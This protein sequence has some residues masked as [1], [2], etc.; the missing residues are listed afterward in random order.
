[1]EYVV[2]GMACIFGVASLY[3]IVSWSYMKAHTPWLLWTIVPHII[4]TVGL[5]YA[6]QMGWIGNIY[7][8]GLLHM[9]EITLFW[10]S[11][12]D[13][14]Y[15][16]LPDEGAVIICI[17]GCL[18]QWIGHSLDLYVLRNTLC[19]GGLWWSLRY[20][21]RGGVGLGDIKWLMAI[22]IWLSPLECLL[23]CGLSSVVGIVYS[24]IHRYTDPA[25]SYIPFGPSLSVAT[26]VLLIY[27]VARY[28]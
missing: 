11:T 5:Q 8:L 14:L 4:G 21:S 24:C 10:G 3:L 20:M 22:S 25:H 2:G 23:L 18:Y 13:K 16:I 17:C 12:I 26:M 27:P 6:Y 15:Y 19:M 28:L 1:M 7:Q 9:L